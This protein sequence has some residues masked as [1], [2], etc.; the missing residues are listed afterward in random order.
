MTSIQRAPSLALLIFSA[1][2]INPLTVLA[3]ANTSLS[4]E[5]L[6]ENRTALKSNRI[7]AKMIRITFPPF[8]KV[9]G[10]PTKALVPAIF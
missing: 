10:I 3:D 7:H 8:I 2:L 9:L 6:F 5:L 4:K 1:C